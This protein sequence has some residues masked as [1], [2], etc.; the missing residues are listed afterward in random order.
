MTDELPYDSEFTSLMLMAIRRYTWPTDKTN[1][2]YLIFFLFSFGDYKQFVF[3]MALGKPYTR[4]MSQ[5]EWN[6]IRRRQQGLLV[7]PPTPNA[8]LPLV[9]RWSPR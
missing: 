1:T 2:M 7:G 6:R 9:G 8:S 5:Q 3:R 4:I